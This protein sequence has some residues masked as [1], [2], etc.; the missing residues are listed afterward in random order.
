M[1]RTKH[2]GIAVAAL[3]VLG[4][5]CETTGGSQFENT[6]YSIHR[7]VDNLEGNLGQ[8]VTR[9]NETSAELSMRVQSSEQQT[10]E[11]RGM[12][13]ENQ[14]QLGRLERDMQHLTKVISEQ[15][16]I[17]TGRPAPRPPADPAQD[18][19]LVTEPPRVVE[20][21]GAPAPTP[22]PTET[23][24]QDLFI[25]DEGITLLDPPAAP[26]AGNPTLDYRRAQDAY[27]ERD[28]ARAVTLYDEFLQKY[29]DNT[30]ALDALFW[31]A[32]SQMNM[33]NHRA[34]INSYSQLRQQYPNDR[35]LLPSAIFNQAIAHSKLGE[36]STAVELM[37][38]VVNQY[39]LTQAAERA[40]RALGQDS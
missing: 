21:G 28:F 18:G 25:E 4:T 31:K 36:R 2:I 13:E 33:D 11:L 32:T 1:L 23:A 5:G 37:E 38:Y 30:R 8:S 17:T 22:T 9:L 40:R 35:E 27:R 29:P 12:I 24:R 14:V 39:P 26:E 7:K 34:A 10:R 3:A 15:Y 16:G 19:F 20:Q 6:V